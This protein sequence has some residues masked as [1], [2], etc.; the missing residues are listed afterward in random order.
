MRRDWLQQLRL[1]C[2]IML[3]RLQELCKNCETFYYFIFILAQSG[4][5]LVQE[6]YFILLQM[7]E[8]L[9]EWSQVCKME[10]IIFSY[11]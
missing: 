11:T 4:K 2:S 1:M 6:F 9:N 10:S 3:M 8:P 7:G 5:I